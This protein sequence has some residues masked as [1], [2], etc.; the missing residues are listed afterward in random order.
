MTLLL[1]NCV[2]LLKLSLHQISKLSNLGA[3]CLSGKYIFKVIDFF[4]H[5]FLIS[6]T[7]IPGLS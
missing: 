6:L 7:T 3:K 4:S 2:T 5:N 1:E